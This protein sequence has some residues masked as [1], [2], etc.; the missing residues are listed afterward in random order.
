MGLLIFGF[1]RFFMLSLACLVMFSLDVENISI[2]ELEP[3]KNKKETEMAYEWDRKL[4]TLG[5]SETL[6]IKD[7]LRKQKQSFATTDYS[8]EL[9]LADIHSF[10]NENDLPEDV[11]KELQETMHLIEKQLLERKKMSEEEMKRME[12]RT[13]VKTAKEYYKIKE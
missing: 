8:T 4:T 3:R 1:G 7:E 10:L 11:T 5:D 6:K 12:A 2:V 13:L 9:P